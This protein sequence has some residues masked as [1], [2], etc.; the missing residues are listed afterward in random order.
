MKKKS[1]HTL[2]MIL[3][4]LLTG[5]S[6]K[7]LKAQSVITVQ[8]SIYTNTHWTAC[9]QYLLMGYVYVCQNAI[10]TIDAGVIIK[11][12]KNT[13]GSL[14]VERGS[15]L[16]ANGTAAEPIVFTSNQAPGSRTYGDWGGVIL[17]GRAFVN[18]N[19]DQ[20]QVEGGPRSLYG[21]A[22]NDMPHDNSGSM[23]YVRIEFAGVAFSPNNEI[24]GLTLCGVGD[25]TNIDHIQVS[26]SGDDSFEWFGGNVNCKYLVA[27]RGWDDDFDTDNGYRGKV[28]FG[29]GIRDPFA[30]DQSGS[31]AFESDSYQSG[32]LTG[33]AGDTTGLTR[34][35]FCNMTV[36]GPLV[37]PTSTAYDPQFVSAAHIRRGDAI[38]IMNSIF[39]GYPC[40]ILFDQSSASYGS[41]TRNYEILGAAGDSIGQ[42]RG[43]IVCG[44]PTNATPVKKELEFVIDG[45]RSLTNTATEADTTSTTPFGS[46]TTASSF[47]GP[48]NLFFDNPQAGPKYQN[49]TYPTEQTGVRLANP[50]NLANPNEVPT[51]TSPVC[52]N[53][54][55]LSTLSTNPSNPNQYTQFTAHY[56]NSNPF[57][58]GSVFP[59]N[60]MLPINTDTTIWLSHY[61]APTRLPVWNSGKLNSPFFTQTNYVGAFS[62]TQTTADDWMNGWC[63]FDPVNTPYN[64]TGAPAATITAA[65]STT[66]CP[67][68]GSV[69]LNGNSGSGYTYQWML[70]NVNINGATN[71]SYTATAAGTYNLV[72]TNSTGC[73]T[74]SANL[75]VSTYAAPTA[76]ITAGGPITFC[77][78]GNVT[79]TA[80]NSSAYS[81]SNGSTTP[82]ITANTAGNYLVTITDVNGCQATSSAV[83]VVVNPLP[84]ATITASGPTSFCTGDS[85]ILTAN[86]SAS[87]LWSTL[88]TTQSITVYNSG[89]Y[90]VQVTNANG[91]QSTVSAPITVSASAS[92]APTITITGN[93][94]ICQGDMVTL[95]ASQGDTYMWSPGGQTTQSITVG[96]AGTYN[97]TETNSNACNGTGTSQNVVVTVHPLP[98]ASYT[99]NSTNM[100]T[101]VFT[102]GSTGATTYTWDFG[103]SNSSSNLSPTHTYSGNGN[104]TACLTAMTSF[105]C[106]DSVCM[107][108]MIN[109]GIN[110]V[111]PAGETTTLYPN[112]ANEQINLEMN[113]L[114]DKEVSIV[115][116]DVTGKLMINENRALTSGNNLMTFDVTNWDNGIYFLRIINDGK[117]NT[118]KVMIN[119]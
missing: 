32:T 118:M 38:S 4:L 67:S 19:G 102:N 49:W 3:V 50:F 73:S 34:P 97:V 82:S 96:T 14:I 28:Q 104:Y 25:G 110:T 74:T 44:I 90:T 108:I 113:V 31:K 59:F 6:A 41:T 84:N 7:N 54:K 60:P 107:P 83:T 16:Y 18:W 17:C 117:V 33:L 57:N 29:C 12:D 45:A 11:G 100:P 15:K 71:Q 21:G 87:Y 13:K 46:A 69:V 92:P 94:S 85:V 62:G 89:N 86:A 35:V 51:S 8:D 68:G 72:V 112:P 88:A 65:G 76:T 56:G 43:D 55:A 23:S 40:G 93:T 115:A 53:S 116:Y 101:V 58:N 2:G 111:T 114:S 64:L 10:L 95:T 91:C 66:I 36:I 9:N 103:D 99:Y 119:K 70:A 63:N 30:A 78:G 24:N 5:I 47:S 52:Y 77:Q 109:V 42:L 79:L 61:N 1:L 80:N 20:S 39:V 27:Y 81:W 106:A 105:G 22:G 48:F 26:Y 37:S 75:V 98:V